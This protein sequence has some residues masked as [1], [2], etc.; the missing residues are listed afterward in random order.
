MNEPPTT[1]ITDSA[2]RTLACY[3]DLEAVVDGTTYG[4]LTP[5]DTPVVLVRRG[6]D[7]DEDEVL[8]W[9]DHE[10]ILS[11]VDHYLEVFGTNSKLIRSAGTLTVSDPLKWESREDV[12]SSVDRYLEA[13]L[14]ASDEHVPAEN[15]DD[16]DADHELL[17]DFEH[18]DGRI[19][20]LWIPLDPFFVVAKARG[21]TGELLEGDEFKRIMPEIERVLEVAG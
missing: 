6:E 20:S 12:L 16:E 14:A 17:I 7:G 10:D 1:T 8:E 4:L 11:A 3:L 2:G 15:E 19:Y 18:T 9:K 13:A 5:V 21:F